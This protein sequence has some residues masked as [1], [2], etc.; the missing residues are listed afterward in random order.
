[1]KC[2][3]CGKVLETECWA[4]E[5]NVPPYSEK[6]NYLVCPDVHLNVEIR[7]SA[8]CKYV[9]YIDIEDNRYRIHGSKSRNITEVAVRLVP[10]MRVSSR[11]KKNPLKIILSVPK[12]I[13]PNIENEI[14]QVQ[15]V[16]DKLL[17]L[18]VFS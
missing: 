12:F 8:I 14:L 3:W 5:F 13:V 16:M 1:M 11:E 9:A 7:D 4:E 18:S 2:H 6:E 10:K 15:Q 17:K